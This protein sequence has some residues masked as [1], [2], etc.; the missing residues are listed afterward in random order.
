MTDPND[1][2]DQGDATARIEDLDGEDLDI[3][4]LLDIESKIEEK[5][6]DYEAKAQGISGNML[7][8]KLPF[9][10]KRL[11]SEEKAALAESLESL[12][13]QRENVRSQLRDRGYGREG[14]AGD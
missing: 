14:S 4:E 1:G 9:R 3:E 13:A 5:I 6:E 7:G 8:E 12:L 11:L 2:W 10:K